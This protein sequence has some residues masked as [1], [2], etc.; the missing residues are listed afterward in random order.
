MKHP[1]EHN[2]ILYWQIACGLLALTLVGIS[3]HAYVNWNSEASHY[4]KEST[5]YPLID[6]ARH[7]I[8]Q[9]NFI[10][11]IQPLRDDLHTLVEEQKDM[12]VS[13]Y[14][15]FLN[16]GANI[17]I[18]NDLAV[19]PASLLKVP[20]AMAVMKKIETGEWKLES[21]LVLAEQ[22]KDP[23]YGKIWQRPS[24]TRFTVRELLVEML[25]NSDNTAYRMFSRN[26]GVDELVAVITDLGIEDL[27]NS[28]GLM[29]SKEYS[30]LFRALY[31]SSFL[32]REN[33]QFLLSLLADPT[34]NG[35]IDAGIPDDVVFAHKFGIN[36]E[37][38]AALDAGIVY[39]PNRPYLIT[40]AIKV[41]DIEPKQEKAVKEFMRK[42]G[43][44]TYEYVSS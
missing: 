19:W 21:E 11:N 36:T 43:E 9:E 3:I 44:L 28:E 41:K 7:L 39:V 14:F 10:V 16:T 27:F 42:V 23:S 8:S 13:L 4:T 20:M 38:G 5:E 29:T 24:G 15:E 6:P 18:N 32:R 22:D 25:G 35:F 2:K 37:H 26:I 30:R 17:S 31:T 33:S 34:F 40:V 12:E 1:P